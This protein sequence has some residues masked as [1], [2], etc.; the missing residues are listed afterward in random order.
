MSW[1]RWS[2]SGITGSITRVQADDS[3]RVLQEA[4]SGP[5]QVGLKRLMDGPGHSDKAKV[6]MRL[7]SD[8]SDGLGQALGLGYVSPGRKL[9]GKLFARV[10]SVQQ[11][12]SSKRSTNQV[13]IGRKVARQLRVM[14]I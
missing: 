5:L 3:A 14:L 6:A 7:A 11:K 9:L 13:L 10:S 12:T 4:G 2:A 1:V 8:D